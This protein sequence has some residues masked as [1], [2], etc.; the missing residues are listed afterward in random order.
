MPHSQEKLIVFYVKKDFCSFL[1]ACSDFYYYFCTRISLPKTL[2]TGRRALPQQRLR[3]LA[4][5]RSAARLKSQAPQSGRVGKDV[6]HTYLRRLLDAL[7]ETRSNLANSTIMVLNLATVD[8][9]G[10]DYII[11][12]TMLIQHGLYPNGCNDCLCICVV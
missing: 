12:V 9:L 5:K 2:G 10:C 4:P 1:F 7:F 3:L 8:V 11:P 6:R